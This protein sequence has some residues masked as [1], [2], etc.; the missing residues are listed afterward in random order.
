MAQRRQHREWLDKVRL[1][2][3]TKTYNRDGWRLL[4]TT[5]VVNMRLDQITRD[6]I[7]I[8][9]FSRVLKCQLRAENVKKDTAQGGGVDTDSPR[10]ETQT[11]EGI[12]TFTQA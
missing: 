4:K 11:D 2:D 9:R 8:L 5:T 6:V 10:S 7:E 3:K 1:E 12:R